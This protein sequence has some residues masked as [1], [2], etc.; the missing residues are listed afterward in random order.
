MR[1][2]LADR[3]DPAA[4]DRARA[5][6]LEVE[7]RAGLSREELLEAIAGFDGLVVRSRTSVDA[8][9]LARADRL[10]VVGRAGTGVD[11]IDVKAA[12]RRGVL[13]MN[14]PGANSNSAAEHALALLLALCRRVPAGDARV[15][16]A[17]WRDG[18]LTGLEVQ[19][20]TLAIIGLGRI[21]Q[22]V[23]AKAQGLGMKVI[24]FDPVTSAEAAARFGV[25]L[26]PLE[27]TLRRADAVTL[28]VPLN[29]STRHFID[30]AAMDS[31][32][33]GALLVNC[34]R[35]GLIDE[36]A[37]ARALEEGHLGGAALDVFE[38]EPPTESPLLALE[39]VILTPHLGASTREA[40]RRVAVEIV[41]A[42]AAHLLEGSTEGALN[43]LARGDLT[44]DELRPFFELAE[45]LGRITAGLEGDFGHL[46]ARYYGAEATELARALTAH[47]LKGFLGAFLDEDVH[48][49]AA[50][51]LARERGMVVDEVLRDE[52]RSFQNLLWYTMEVGEKQ[53]SL[54][55]TLFGK[56]SLRLV[57]VAGM[58]LDA[59]PEGWM[60]LVTNRD[61]P[62][63]MGHTATAL[64]EAGVNIGNLSLGRRRETGEA[65]AILNLDSRPPA[66]V[67]AS[68]RQ[69]DG[70]EDVRLINVEGIR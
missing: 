59:V 45:R 8:D 49:L 29:E 62:G 66:S 6:G 28:H 42:M 69:I 18:A 54:A 12:T 24:G 9:V 22:L 32:K 31:M 56:N 58:N 20:K 68:I 47:F 52:H 36:D 17:G 67:L 50:L 38:T 65:L 46:T 16:S 1:I 55:G 35:G 25:E 51:D 21:G 23:A 53:R 43:A 3:L 41:E 37:L 39:N 64:G 48:E 30:E 4:Q 40:Q 14:T 34:A 63:V 57:R 27:E 13:V 10:K 33:P 61:R 5:L 15:R 7:D 26:L 60:L 44:K 19:G 2:L 70:V 11:N